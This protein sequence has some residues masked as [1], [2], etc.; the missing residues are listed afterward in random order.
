M[1]REQTCPPKTAGIDDFSAVIHYTKVACV[2]VKQQHAT[3]LTS[4]FQRL[5]GDRCLLELDCT[6]K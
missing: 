2:N 1:L 6:S 3:L 4:L 5:S